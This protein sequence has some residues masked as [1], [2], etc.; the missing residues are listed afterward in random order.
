M[1]ERQFSS[2]YINDSLYGIDILVISDIYRHLD[3]TPVHK[4]PPYVRGLLNLRGQIVTV[5]DLGIKLGQEPTE[6]DE[7]TRCIILKTNSDMTLPYFEDDK[8]VN[9]GMHVVGLLV[10]KIGE[11]IKIN[12]AK[13]Q[14][15]PANVSKDKKKYISGIAKLDREIL[16]VIKISEVLN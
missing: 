8:K 14:K 16:S 12:E 5:L 3:M 13:I 4:L 2:F 15:A 9:M 10:D 6:I 7:Q 11:V 1:S